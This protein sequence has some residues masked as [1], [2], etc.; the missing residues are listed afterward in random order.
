MQGQKVGCQTQSE[1]WGGERV[2]GLGGAGTD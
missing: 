1:E 2:E